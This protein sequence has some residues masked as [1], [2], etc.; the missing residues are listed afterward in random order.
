MKDPPLPIALSCLNGVKMSGGGVLVAARRSK[1]RL[2]RCSVHKLSVP[3]SSGGFQYKALISEL[4]DLVSKIISRV[5]QRIS[6]LYNFLIRALG[7][8]PPGRE[9]DT[10]LMS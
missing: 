1:R 2:S 7:T 5:L 8:L 4:L 3:V 9:Q 10:V 6:N